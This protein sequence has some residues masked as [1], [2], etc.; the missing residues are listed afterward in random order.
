MTISRRALHIA[1]VVAGLTTAG[2]TLL[3]AQGGAQA[4]RSP[5]AAASASALTRELATGMLQTLVG[6][7]Q[8][9]VRFGGN[10]TGAPDAS[11][12]RVFAPLFEELRLEWTESLDSSA[13][14]ARGV[15]GFD[16]RT[17]RFYSMGV[18]S[19]SH[20]VELLTG[21]MDPAEPV[22]TFTPTAPATGESFI[23]RVIDADRF[24]WAPLDGGWRAV[25]RREK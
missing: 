4:K 2:A 1:V 8:F 11:G 5:A 17:G 25:F 9:E 16:P 20:G 23:L 21:S 6:A 10:F 13:T 18:Y 7:W 15:V 14:G 3:T 12:R 19:S 22:I 24:T